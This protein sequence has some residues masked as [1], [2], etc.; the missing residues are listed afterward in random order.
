MGKVKHGMEGTRLYKIWDS[1]KQRCLNPNNPQYNNYGG[2]G[3]TIYAEWHDFPN[4]MKWALQNGYCE[5]LSIDRI[6]VNG[7]YHPGNCRWASQRT[8]NNNRRNNHLLTYNGRTHTIAEWGKITGILPATIHHRVSRDGWS[9]EDALTVTPKK[10]NK[11]KR[12]R[13]EVE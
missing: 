3:I 2:R 5:N 13:Q 1:M 7:N 8:Q 10:G 9:V 4:F 6:D 12:K 11:I